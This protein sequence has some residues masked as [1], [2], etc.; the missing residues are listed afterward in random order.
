[1]AHG[2][3]QSGAGC[4]G[5]PYSTEHHLKEELEWEREEFTLARQEWTW[6]RKELTAMLREVEEG[7]GVLDTTREENKWLHMLMRHLKAEQATEKGERGMERV[8]M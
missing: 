7:E 8:C 6:E 5:Q 2:R 4:A 1:M 3:C